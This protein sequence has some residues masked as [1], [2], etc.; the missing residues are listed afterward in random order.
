MYT[1]QTHPISNLAD[2]LAHIQYTTS[3][4]E[5]RTYFVVC[6]SRL[7][8]CHSYRLYQWEE[9]LLLFMKMICFGTI[10]L[11]VKVKSCFWMHTFEVNVSH[12]SSSSLKTNTVF[13]RLFLICWHTWHITI[14]NHSNF[15]DIS[16]LSK[17]NG[18]AFNR[19][20]VHRFVCGYNIACF[21]QSYYFYYWIVNWQNNFQ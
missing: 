18:T 12:R 14:S 1:I 19:A 2:C 15:I 5:M 13:F 7:D 3:N 16:I 21:W 10:L 11:H 9:T 4:I 20:I 17:H 8:V 6:I